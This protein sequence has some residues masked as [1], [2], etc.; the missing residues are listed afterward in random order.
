M[1]IQTLTP[2]APDP[3]MGPSRFVIWS[4]AVVLANGDATSPVALAQG[5]DDYTLAVTGTFGAGGTCIAEGSNDGTTWFALKD[6][7]GAAVSITAA[8]F[9][10]IAS[11]ALRYARA[12]V[13]AG[14]GTTQLTAQIAMRTRAKQ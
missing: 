3:N 10:T 6:N 14:D 13:S 2:S 9:Q 12:R 4:N 11:V 1:A 8:G 5:A 7:V